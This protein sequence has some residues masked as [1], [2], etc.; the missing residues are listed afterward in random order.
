MDKSWM[1]NDRLS[2]EYTEGVDMF[3]AFALDH[4]INLKRVLCL[5][6]G[7]LNL[8]FQTSTEIKY[9]LFSKGID[10][11]YQ[12]WIFHGES[13]PTRASTSGKTTFVEPPRY[14]KDAN[15][16]EMVHDAFEF[17]KEYPKSFQSLLEDA[18]KPLFPGCTKYTKVSA[19]MKLYNRKGKYGW[20]DNSFSDLLSALTDTFPDGNEMPSSMYEAKKTITALGLEYEKIHAC[21]NDCI[22]YR[23]DYKDLSSCPI[24][25]E[26]R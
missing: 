1:K 17:C 8:K 6:Q 26:S 10:Q 15:M 22:L 12:K 14:E 25:K 19:L 9:H 5:C 20:S 7:C 4:T 21:P 24:C 2:K 18:E 23:N 3:I 11:R 16:V 13:Y